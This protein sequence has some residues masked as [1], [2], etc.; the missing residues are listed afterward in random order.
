[1]FQWS[2]LNYFNG[3]FCNEEISVNSNETSI[4]LAFQKQINIQ[5]MSLKKQI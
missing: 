5:I 1:M 2:I 4:T 3:V